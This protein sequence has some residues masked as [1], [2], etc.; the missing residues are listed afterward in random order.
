M[1]LI[2]ISVG[3]LVIIAALAAVILFVVAKKFHVEEDPRIDEVAELLP[4]ANCG[5]CG[6]A[7]CRALAEAIC[8]AGNFEGKFCPVGGAVVMEQIA[9]II[10]AKTIA[11][12]PK[13]AVVRCNGTKINS[14]RNVDFDGLSSCRFSFN[15][16]T[17]VTGCPHGC[18]GLGDCT[19]SCQFDAIHLDEESG[20]PIVD[21]EKC[22]ACGTCVKVC[23][24]GVIQLRD[25]GKDN[26]RIWVRCVN[27]EK[28]ALAK[29]HCS[30]TC[31]GCG[32]CMKECQYGAINLDNN[33]AYIDF[34]K[35]RLCRK[36]VSAC[37]TGAIAE[38]NFDEN[39][40][41]EVNI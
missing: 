37:P 3:I 5:G 10:G 27:K 31:I 21:E 25:K 4:G 26:H 32:K 38:V 33:V 16:Y 28:G 9:P 8:K 18:V 11:V 22:V 24:R 15:L 30:A 19:R 17:G 39:K 12:A 6:Y 23:P 35:C 7:G 2:Y 14:P 13:V 36:C 29:K 34:N 41:E 40:V 20:L 1:Q